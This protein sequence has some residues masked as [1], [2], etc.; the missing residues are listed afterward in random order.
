MLHQLLLVRMGG[1]RSMSARSNGGATRSPGGLREGGGPGVGTRGFPRRRRYGGKTDA[2]GRLRAGFIRED[3]TVNGVMQRGVPHPPAAGS[4][5]ISCPAKGVR[6][7][8]GQRCA[9]RCLCFFGSKRYT[10]S[11]HTFEDSVHLLHAAAAI[12][13]FC[14]HLVHPRAVL[15]SV[16]IVC[17]SH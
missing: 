14:R 3:S 5:R 10:D 8:V 9:S 11:T 4:L 2:V 13:V 15:S 7:G 17:A 16:V 1:D 12:V 6:A